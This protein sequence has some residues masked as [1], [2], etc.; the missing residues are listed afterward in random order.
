[1]K[2]KPGRG[3]LQAHD[4][5][6][7]ALDWTTRDA[8]CDCGLVHK[9]KYML[10]TAG[11]GSQMLLQRSTRDDVETRAMRRANKRKGK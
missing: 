8:C 7:I 4:D 3:Y 9:V 5:E 2:R 10:A 6:W 1:M 11:D